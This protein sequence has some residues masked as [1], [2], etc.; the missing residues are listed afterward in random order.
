MVQLHINYDD[1]VWNRLRVIKENALNIEG[2]F[3]VTMTVH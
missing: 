3:I 1:H 2:K